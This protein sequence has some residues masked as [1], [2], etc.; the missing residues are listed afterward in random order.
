[1][2]G[3][4]NPAAFW[5][6]PIA[7]LPIVIHL[8]RRHRAERVMFP[9]LRF[10][11]SAQ[12]AAVRMQ[13]PSDVRL[14]AIRVGTLG[15]AIAALAG[16]IALTGSRV[17]EWNA[18]VSRAII[19]DTSESMTSGAAGGEQPE[20][21]AAEAARAEALTATYSV[22]IETADLAA[23]L[24]RARVW[25]ES[26]PPAR[27]EVVFISD[28]QLGVLDGA[29]LGIESLHQTIGLR[30]VS[31][32]RAVDRASVAGVDALAAGRGT[33]PRTIDLTHHTTALAVGSAAG[34]GT[35]GVRII[36]DA[37]V[38][39]GAGASTALLRA[40]AI[41]GAPA[42]SLQEPIAI[43]FLDRKHQT[44]LDGL[45]HVRAGWMLRTLL[46][47]QGDSELQSAALLLQASG[48]AASQ[49]E[50]PTTHW[51]VVARDSSGN[52][53]VLAAASGPELV[54]DVATPSE[55][56]FAALLLRGVLAARRS[57]A[58]YS[59]REIARVDEAVLSSVRREPSPVDAP[60][61]RDASAFWRRVDA[62]DAR[63][64]WLAVLVGLGIEQWF[65]GRR[66][67]PVAE[68]GVTRAAA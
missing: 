32:G 18:A 13:R 54:L 11:R 7:A 33:R 16:P 20:R 66:S 65:R 8:L 43:R 56:L 49:A 35:S 57:A 59:E 64:C 6:L 36:L 14:M 19:V 22:R 34:E 31:I 4:Q 67:T 2:I 23:G 62:T 46:R 52:P 25:L 1:V 60:S 44:L 41:A 10:V 51:S 38:D 45:H 48:P 37:G 3:W 39:A 58:D 47:L 63:W 28:L 27:Q 9:S 53:V 42:G 68:T 61:G 17:A 12:T 26:A 55:S 5:A 24:L 29:A 50:G 40:V 15:V 30:F 21:L